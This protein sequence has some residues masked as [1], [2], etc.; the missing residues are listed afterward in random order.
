MIR[1]LGL[2]ELSGGD[3][4]RPRQHADFFSYSCHMHRLLFQTMIY[5]AVVSIVNVVIFAIYSFQCATYFTMREQYGK[6]MA[7]I[8]SV[9][10]I[11]M[12]SIESF[13]GKAL[14]RLGTPIDTLQKKY[15]PLMFIIID[16][17][18]HGTAC[19]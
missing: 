1:Q 10:C 18:I 15:K 11:C 19:M 3:S 6:W 4:A 12:R 2:V 17:S 7:K 13:K 16:D 5:F 9:K 8:L 14:V